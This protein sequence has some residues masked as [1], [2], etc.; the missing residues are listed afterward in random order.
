MKNKGSSGV[1][2]WIITILCILMLIMQIGGVGNPK[3]L[4]EEDVAEIVVSAV[5]SINIPSADI[6]YL[7][8]YGIGTTVDYCEKN[9]VNLIIECEQCGC[10]GAEYNEDFEESF[11]E[12]CEPTC[13]YCGDNMD[14]C[15]CNSD[16]TERFE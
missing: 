7:S 6:L 4:S 1:F 8:K 14:S 15:L 3:T 2:S 11:C 16:N 13:I 12:D 9:K 5:G 10:E